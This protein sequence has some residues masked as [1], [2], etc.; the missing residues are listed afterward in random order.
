MKGLCLE[1]SVLQYWDPN[2]AVVCQ[3]SDSFML[4]SLRR[5]LLFVLTANLLDLLLIFCVS[6][7][8][9]LITAP[10]PGRKGCTELH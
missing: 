7:G 2:I 4:S 3:G 8:K 10:V 5:L 1:G 9:Y 6:L